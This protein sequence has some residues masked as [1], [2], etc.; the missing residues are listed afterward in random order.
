MIEKI[1]E[2]E[3]AI[4][5]RKKGKTYSEILKVVPVAKS[6]LTLW[7]QSVG[8]SNKQK[9]RIT[10]K[11]LDCS[12]RGGIAKRKQRIERQNN[13]INTSKSEIKNISK[14]D[15]FLI[16]VILY[17]AEGTKEKEHK[18]GT[19]VAFSNMDPRM[20][21]LFLKWLKD[22]CKISN[23]MIGFEIMVHESHK[24]RLDEVK[25]YWSNI[26]GFPLNSF[27]KLYLKKNK[28]KKTNR[29]NIGEKYYGV[30]K[31]HVKESSNLVRKITGWTDGIFEKVFK[32]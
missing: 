3:I 6:T 15:L 32:I 24:D 2:K 5:L 16:G 21:I 8:L 30:L 13:I 7:L 23:N 31:I 26:T 11:R 29:K 4:S 10:Q 27:S 20:I 25:K 22:I 17:W 12:I 19:G 14:N 28:I 9:Q 18:P 1:N